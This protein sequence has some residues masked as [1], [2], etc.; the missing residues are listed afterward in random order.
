MKHKNLAAR[1]VHWMRHTPTGQ[2]AFDNEIWCP[3]TTER[4][5]V[6]GYDEEV[7]IS[8]KIKGFK[9][10]YKRMDWD[11]PAPTVTMANGSINSQN[12]VHP[13]RRNEDGTFSDARV[14]TIRELCAIVGLPLG[15]VDHLEHTQQRESFLRKVLGECFPPMMAK[16]IVG[17]MPTVKGE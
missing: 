5:K 11:N 12:N 2:T 6:E 3:C 15:W 14:L 9:T 7:E 17:K 4:V 16:H 1:H 10:T 13:G 8:R